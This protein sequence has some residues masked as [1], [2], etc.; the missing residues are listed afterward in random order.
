MHVFSWKQIVHWK[1]VLRS[2]SR[3]N[4]DATNFI[5]KC[6]QMYQCSPKPTRPERSS[7]LYFCFTWLNY[8]H[9]RKTAAR[10]CTNT[11]H[12]PQSIRGE[13]RRTRTLTGNNRQSLWT[14][15]PTRPV[16]VRS[17]VQIYTDI[18]N[19]TTVLCVI[20]YKIWLIRSTSINNTKSLQLW[21]HCRAVDG[22]LRAEKSDSDMTL[23]QPTAID[24]RALHAQ[25]HAVRHTQT[26]K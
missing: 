12:S 1:W 11:L 3:R 14:V 26:T 8:T 20:Y 2:I 15:T 16:P 25:N 19:S 21:R 5:I 10:G 6:S 13:S 9:G 17:V 18:N 7:R 23:M 4:L 24:W 22:T